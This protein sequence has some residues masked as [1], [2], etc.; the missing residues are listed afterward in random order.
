[1]SKDFHFFVAAHGWEEPGQQTAPPGPEVLVHLYVKSGEA[2]GT[3]FAKEMLDRGFNGTGFATDGS[4]QQDGLDLWLGK[5]KS[6]PYEEVCSSLIGLPDLWMFGESGKQG[7]PKD[8]GCY[9]K[10]SGNSRVDVANWVYLP[11]LSFESESAWDT[12]DGYQWWGGKKFVS[13]VQVVRKAREMCA[14][15]GDGEARIH[16][17]WLQCRSSK[18]GWVS[19]EI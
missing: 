18:K 10:G 5:A 16:L 12:V 14:V 4:I 2:M 1:M 15:G 3:R 8:Y 6:T 11:D 17:H 13:I 19:R 9:I 7:T